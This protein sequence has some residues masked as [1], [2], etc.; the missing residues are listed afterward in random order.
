MSPSQAWAA[1]GG[2]PCSGPFAG[3]VRSSESYEVT[4]AY[5]QCSEHQWGPVTTERQWR[6]AARGVG[7]GCRW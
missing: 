4:V 6:C 3:A 7:A 2:V 5:S 1:A